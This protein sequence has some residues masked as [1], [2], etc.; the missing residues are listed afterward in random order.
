MPGP[1]TWK[2]VLAK[3][4]PTAATNLVANP[5]FTTNASSWDT[6]GSSLL[7]ASPA[8]AVTRETASWTG[9]STG[10]GRVTGTGNA[11]TSGTR[12]LVARTAEMAVTPNSTYFAQ[13]EL[14]PVLWPTGAPQAKGFSFDVQFFAS[15]GATTTLAGGKSTGTLFDFNASGEAKPTLAVRAPAKAAFARIRVI[16]NADTFLSSPLEF[17]ID[18]AKF[19]SL[20]TL[21]WTATNVGDLAN[22]RERRFSFKLNQPQTL[23]FDLPIEDPLA[24]EIVTAVGAATATPIVKLYRDTT[25]MMVAEILTAEIVSAS[26]ATTVRVVATETMW[27]RLQKRLLVDS[28]STTGYKVATP[29][30]RTVLIQDQLSNLNTESPTGID[31]G[32]SSTSATSSLTTFSAVRAEGSPI[33]AAVGGVDTTTS[34]STGITGGPW[35]YKPFMEWLQELAFT[36]NGFDFWQDP[37]DP[38]T[39]AGVSGS[40]NTDE[41][42]GQ[43]RP[44]AIFEFGTGRANLVEYSYTMT[45]EQL[46]NRGW[47]LPPAFP[48]GTVVSANDYNSVAAFRMREE[49]I[50][51]D[52]VAESLRQNLANEHVAV[53]KSFRR[54]FTFVPQIED[55]TRTPRFGVDYK[56]GDYV[57]G[58]VR[59]NEILLLAGAVRV[60]GAD[61]EVSN[62]G[63]VKT[64]LTVVQEV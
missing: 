57:E 12:Q 28:K 13:I 50:S 9:H 5:E 23:S 14:K 21:A 3:E 36:L 11:T 56:I 43:A 24:A 45:G 54:V 35:T 53:R 32:T 17:L 61:I 52:I 26:P 55:G 47:V 7:A 20:S 31:V 48:A 15:S 62:E 60:Y 6:T 4:E 30:E 44:E 42:R 63:Q 2:M 1:E 8:A 39:N 10:Y 41:L 59:D 34:A 16:L 49:V 27:Q 58:R 19:Y 18:N 46:I 33:T 25:L 29:T 40:L 38:V 22:A 37:L 64:T 51:T